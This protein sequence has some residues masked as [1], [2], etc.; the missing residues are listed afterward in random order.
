MFAAA[1]CL[2]LLFASAFAAVAAEKGRAKAKEGIL[3]V[4]FGTSEPDARGA[5]AKIVDGVK[6]AFPEADVRLSFT[7]NIIRRKVL[8]EEGIAFDS[9]LIALAKMQDEGVSSVTVQSLHIIP[10]EE[11]NQLASVVRSLRGIEGK[12]AFSSLN[13]GAPLL[14]THEDYEKTVALLKKE[15]GELAGNGGAVVFMGHGTHHSA[16]AAYAQMQLMFDDAA[17]P[18]VIGTVEGYP[19]LDTVKRRLA[20][21]KP[22]KVTLVPFM[23]VAGDHAKNDMSAKDDPESWLSVLS[24]EGYSVNALLKGLGDAAGLTELFVGHIREAA[25]K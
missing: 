15:Y 16:N 1:L 23:V 6:K 24:K 18:F 13:L 25:R 10:G 2:C 7:S 22:S 12:Y 19:D 4:A 20:S 8:K 5:I 17:L 21:M 9:P 14:E 3:L 11:Y